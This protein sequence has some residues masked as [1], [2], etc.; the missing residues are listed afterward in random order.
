M[1]ELL[2]HRQHV[3]KGG[4]DCLQGYIERK[5]S[6]ALQKAMALRI[7]TGCISTGCKIIEAS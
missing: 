7:F 1:Q 4:V 5:T 3:V 2:M 6:F